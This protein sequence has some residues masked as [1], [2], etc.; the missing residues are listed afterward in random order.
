MYVHKPQYHSCR[1][2]W[3]YSLWSGLWN[4]LGDNIEHNIFPYSSFL[5]DFISKCFFCPFLYPV[6]CP[7]I[8]SHLH[9]FSCFS[10]CRILRQAPACISR[11][12]E[13][14]SPAWPGCRCAISVNT[15]DKNSDENTAGQLGRP[16]PGCSFCGGC[17]R[18]QLSWD[19]F[20]HCSF[21]SGHVQVQ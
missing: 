11:R 6:V 13:W 8:H 17:G 7:F 18:P 1:A 12:A 4:T 20:A 19:C 9:I 2:T 3:V 15:T 14:H 10:E 16:A 5:A 21:Q